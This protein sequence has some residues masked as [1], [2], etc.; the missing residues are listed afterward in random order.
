MPKCFQGCECLHQH[1]AFQWKKRFAKF[2]NK[3]LPIRIKLGDMALQ[4]FG[5]DQGI[6]LDLPETYGSRT[7]GFI[8]VIVLDTNIISEVMRPQPNSA[9]LAWLN[10][11][12]SPASCSSLA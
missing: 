12:N 2:S 5:K 4:L 9:V 7:H 8:A 11:Q 1:M 3:P 10:Q 6:E